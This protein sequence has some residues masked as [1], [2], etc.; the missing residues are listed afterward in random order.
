MLKTRKS[1]R[2]RDILQEW[3]WPLRFVSNDHAGYVKNDFRVIQ[4]VSKNVHFFNG[5]E[6]KGVHHATVQ[7]RT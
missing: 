1:L 7:G 3:Y 5:N 2:K 6:K 4:L